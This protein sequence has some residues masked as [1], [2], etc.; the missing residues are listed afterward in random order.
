MYCF[1][2]YIL[3]KNKEV[4]KKKVRKE[5]N[6]KKRTLNLTVLKT[7][8]QS[9]ADKR[10]RNKREHTHTF[11]KAN[12]T[13]FVQRNSRGRKKSQLQVIP[14]SFRSLFKSLPSIPSNTHTHAFAK[15]VRNFKQAEEVF[16][17]LSVVRISVFRERVR[18]REYSIATRE[19]R[20][21]SVL[22]FDLGVRVKV[23][24]GSSKFPRVAHDCSLILNFCS[25]PESIEISCRCV[26]YSRVIRC[27]THT[28]FR[29][30]I[31]GIIA[32]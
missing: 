15:E 24:K 10:K 19:V 21:I 11:S 27:T 7:H 12:L 3:I 17:L 9:H 31:F 8:T 26:V 4:I 23:G 2:Q 25:P 14:P 20:V 16:F 18:E 1:C 5:K 6:L 22:L 30:S 29:S 32:G 13:H 28:L